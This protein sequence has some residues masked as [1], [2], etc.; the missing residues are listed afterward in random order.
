MS[1]RRG[2]APDMRAHVARLLDLTLRLGER[3][4]RTY[5]ARQRLAAWLDGTGRLRLEDVRWLEGLK[6]DGVPVAIRVAS[7]PTD[8]PEAWTRPRGYT[9]PCPE[10]GSTTCGGYYKPDGNHFLA[11]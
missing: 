9:G 10:C 4:P 11:F 3:G 6:V 1:P 7:P 5:C 2:I 8:P